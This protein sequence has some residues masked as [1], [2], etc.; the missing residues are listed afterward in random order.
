MDGAEKGV[1]EGRFS[2]IEDVSS[3]D[4]NGVGVVCCGGGGREYCA[5]DRS[6]GWERYGGGQEFV[7][8]VDGWGV[9]GERDRA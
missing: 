5:C 2:G 6:V 9:Q 8:K 7:G 4:L 3:C 1:Q